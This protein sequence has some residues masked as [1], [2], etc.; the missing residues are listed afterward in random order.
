MV[1]R[2]SGPA[3]S[4]QW[5]IALPSLLALFVA[6]RLIVIAVAA[7]VEAQFPLSDPTQAFSSVPILTSLTTSDAVWYLGIARD[8]YHLAA[9]AGSYHD[10]VFFPLFPLLV[11]VASV[12]T[13][14]NV[15]LAGVL[16]A[17]AAA[18]GAMTL[19]YRLSVDRL[20][21]E[22]AL[23]SVA[24]LAIA[25]G[26]VAF[27]M[28]YS[29]SLFL[30]LSLGAFA[31][32]AGRRDG[33]MGI[34]Y[35]LAALTRLPGV[36]LGIPLLVALIVRDGRMPTARWLW[37]AL[38][39]LALAA[40]SGYLWQFS[41][42]PLAFLHGQVAWNEPRLSPVQG[43]SIATRTQPLFLILAAVLLAYTFLLVYLRTDR[44]PLA[45]ATL[46]IVTLATIL[47]SGRILSAPR[48]LAIAWPFAQI[49]AVRQR[50]WF[51]ASWPIVLAGSFALFAFL[52]FTA[53][54]AP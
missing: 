46:A 3:P 1:E 34:L 42:D 6:T 17:N 49:Q 37:L 28:A 33:A 2:H 15:A 40:F 12:L 43:G 35:G 22:D 19:L 45:E 24:F 4:I 8:G 11:R 9:V 10:Y 14:G 50:A 29:D 53:Q 47:L 54:L 38:G 41:G 21:H 44:T 36:L 27:A 26:A 48:Y 39:P 30:L 51:R 25:P 18:F 31:A 23:R 32:V 52:H 7:I 20:G 16:V 13:L 5:R